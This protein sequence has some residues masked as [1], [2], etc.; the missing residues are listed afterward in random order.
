MNSD[1]ASNVHFC[2]Y[3]KPTQTNRYF[4]VE[5]E[6]VRHC[7]ICNLVYRQI[8]IF[9][10]AIVDYYRNSYYREWGQDQ[11]SLK[12]EIIYLDALE[13]LENHVGKGLLLD[14]GAGS[15]T[16]L[17]LARDRGWK[18]MGQEISIESCHLAEQKYGLKLKNANL[19]EIIWEA[20]CFDAITMINV[21]DHL[22]DPWWVLRK[23]FNAL[24]DGGVIY[25]RVPNGYLHSSLYRISNN[26]PVISGMCQ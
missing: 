26:I 18:T 23:A 15:G 16:L 7:A 17:A 9:D 11:E 3:C 6:W 14:I 13:I 25:I 2:P 22:P 10:E 8:K 1:R 19:R 12:R 24:K 5:N 20:N 4:L 21:L